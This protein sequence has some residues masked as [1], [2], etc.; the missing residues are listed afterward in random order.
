MTKR[1]NLEQRN[2]KSWPFLDA[3][4]GYLLLDGLVLDR[5]RSNM[6]P[7]ALL[8]LM[9]QQLSDCYS[10]QCTLMELSRCGARTGE[11]AGLLPT[12]SCQEHFRGSQVS[13]AL[14]DLVAAAA[15][16]ALGLLPSDVVVI[17]IAT[18][19]FGWSGD[20]FWWTPLLVGT[21]G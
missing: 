8:V 6:L 11:T 5:R 21:S 2:G 10:P 19:V 9:Q 16:G 14:M 18:K 1:D 13:P 12:F 15:L 7:P 4:G 20:S 3:S 17:I